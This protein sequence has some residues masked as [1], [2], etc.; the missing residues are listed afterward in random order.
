MSSPVFHPG[1]AAACDAYVQQMQ[2]VY[3]LYKNQYVTTRFRMPV[4]GSRLIIHH[5]G[6]AQAVNYFSSLMHLKC[7]EAS[8]VEA[9]SIVWVDRSQSAGE[10]PSPPLADDQ[11]TG[12]GQRGFI[13]WKDWKFLHA[14]TI[15]LEIWYHIPSHS[16]VVVT[17]GVEELS[18]YDRATPFQSIIHWILEDAGWHMAHA[19]VVGFQGKGALLVGNSG[20]G[21]ST[22]ALTCL[23][24][25][26]LQFLCDDKCMLSLDPNPRAFAIYNAVKLNHDVKDRFPFFNKMIVGTD[27][28]AKKGKNLAFLYPEFKDKTVTRLQINSILIPRI[29]T[30]GPFGISP[31]SPAAAFRVFGPSTSIWV[32]LSGPSNYRFLRSFTEKIP[33]Y[34]LDLAPELQRNAACIKDHLIRLS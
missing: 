19:A 28:F 30:H 34:Y 22:T 32:P 2:E 24:N 26:E 33:C 21:K 14:P 3:E 9:G 1:Q 29:N 20:S 15:G 11:Y 5:D 12:Y 16:G 18:I 23:M 6:S 31:A 27:E 13:H 4:E 10:I 25:P 7:D 8:G 17:R